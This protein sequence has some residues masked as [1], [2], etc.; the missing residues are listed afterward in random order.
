MSSPLTQSHFAYTQPNLNIQRSTW[1]RPSNNHT[2]FNAG[3]LIPIY[4]DEMLPGDTFE[5][6]T[7]CLCRMST[8]IFPVMDNATLEYWYF[9]VP[10]RLVWDHAKEFFGQSD[11]HWTPKLD[12]KIPF[13]P[14]S[15]VPIA[16]NS[17]ADKFGLPAGEFPILNESISALPFRAYRLI[18]N[19]WFRSEAVQEPVLVRTGDTDLWDV[20]E[21]LKVCK[22]FDYFTGCLPQPQRGES[23]TIPGFTG[24]IPV[25][26]TEYSNNYSNYG[27]MFKTV[28]GTDM[29]SAGNIGTASVSGMAQYGGT[30]NTGNTPHSV[31]PRNLWAD[32][33][34]NVGTINQLR[35]AFAIQRMLE[36][37]AR[38]GTRY[39]EIIREHF[40]VTSPD[41]RQQRPEYLGGGYIPINIEQVLQTSSTDSTSPQ[42]NT[43]A[44]SKS[45]GRKKNFVYSATEHGYLI[46]LA[47]V[48]TKHT[49]Q[50]GINR[51][52]TRRERYDFYWPSLANIGEMPVKRKEIYANGSA[53]DDIVFGYQE[54]WADYRY[55][56][57]T[58]CGMFRHKAKNGSLDAWTYAEYYSK[59]PILSAEWLEETNVNVDRTLAVQSDISDQFL[60]DW[61]FNVRAYRPM[62]VNSIPGLVDHY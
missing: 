8:P 51:L 19:E 38:G 58:V 55:K 47:A 26:S 50:Q 56:P 22:P 20:N 9:F 23:V 14:G 31:M 16:I 34:I 40:G 62:P 29:T 13:L 49:Y 11:G 18:W 25:G 37:D 39:T 42:G 54:A 53:E 36:K 35:Q 4:L 46:G 30:S 24:P 3:E 27:L 1:N 2:S 5:M 17:L 33:S 21:I 60:T 45:T 57:D 43:A 28:D 6:E 7:S 61:Y 10:M 52:W 44:Y 12:Y 32:T 48:R 15:G 41:A 59:A